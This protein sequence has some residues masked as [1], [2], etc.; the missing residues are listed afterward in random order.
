MNKII[1]ASRLNGTE[2]IFTNLGG[3]YRVYPLAAPYAECQAA[4]FTTWDDMW[5]WVLANPA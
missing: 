2:Y 4:T 1:C 3:R 5:A